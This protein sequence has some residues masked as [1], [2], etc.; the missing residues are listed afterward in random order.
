MGYIKWSDVFPVFS[1]LF[2]VLAIG[3]GNNTDRI[4]QLDTP[5]DTVSD[6]VDENIGLNETTESSSLAN[7]GYILY[8]TE[9]P[10]WIVD[11]E[12]IETLYDGRIIVAGSNA[13]DSMAML[14]HDLGRVEGYLFQ[15]GR[16]AQTAIR[17][18]GATIYTLIV[19]VL[20]KY[21]ISSGRHLDV[22]VSLS[23]TAYWTFDYNSGMFLTVS[24][25]NNSTVLLQWINSAGT[26]IQ[27]VED[28]LRIDGDDNPLIMVPNGVALDS[29]RNAWVTSG[30]DDKV[31]IYRMNGQL[32]TTFSNTYVPVCIRRYNDKMVIG[33]GQSFGVYDL[34]GERIQGGMFPDYCIDFSVAANGNIVALT[35]SGL[36]LR[37]DIP[38]LY[39]Y[40]A[41]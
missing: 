16:R 15:E 31:F 13:S 18:D 28:P 7:P 26:V 5:V 24:T 39:D 12:L 10:E 8:S 3:C 34:D 2:V 19:L 33:S 25:L 37:M 4:D 30:A 14:S 41:N 11:P 38:C 9:L 23:S 20:N 1:V 32:L 40:G 6:I 36:V 29:N 17:S 35:R 27:S 21:D 22:P